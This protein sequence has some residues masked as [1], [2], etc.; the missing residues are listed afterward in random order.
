[1][2]IYSLQDCNLCIRSTVMRDRVRPGRQAVNRVNWLTA[3]CPHTYNLQSLFPTQAPSHSR[4]SNPSEPVRLGHW[5]TINGCSC[6]AWSL[7]WLT[8]SASVCTIA[9]AHCA[10]R[11]SLPSAESVRVRE[12]SG[13]SHS[14]GERQSADLKN[15]CGS[16]SAG[17]RV[18]RPHI[19]GAYCFKNTLLD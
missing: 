18:R 8:Q 9:S 16:A 17:G 13:A 5:R 14:R 3:R 2:L 11:V 1:M 19:S 6:R 4:V 7:G 15:S 10:Q 12:F